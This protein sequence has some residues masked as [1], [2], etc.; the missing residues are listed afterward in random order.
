MAPRRSKKAAEAQSLRIIEYQA[1]ESTKDD[2]NIDPQLLAQPV[3]T[4]QPSTPL[5]DQS[6]RIERLPEMIR[7]LFTGLPDQSQDG[8]R[9]DPRFKKEA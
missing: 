5:E 1:K 3:T 4:W 9:A 2:S 8:K 6:D 7:V